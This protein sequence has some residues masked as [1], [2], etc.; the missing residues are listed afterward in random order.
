MAAQFYYMSDMGRFT[1]DELRR[2]DNQ[3]TENM[4]DFYEEEMRRI[5]DGDNPSSLL[6]KPIINKFVKMGLLVHVM[7]GKRRRRTLSA[8]A[9]E[10]YGLPPRKRLLSNRKSV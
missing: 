1:P 6:S 8:G 10:W 5:A 3:S 2:L 9:R 4:L 7:D